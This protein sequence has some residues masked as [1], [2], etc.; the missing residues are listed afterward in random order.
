[1]N[2]QYHCGVSPL[3]PWSA[4]EPTSIIAKVRVREMNLLQKSLSEI[5]VQCISIGLGL[6]LVFGYSGSWL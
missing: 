1:M 2:Y 5:T 4:I 3:E 6:V